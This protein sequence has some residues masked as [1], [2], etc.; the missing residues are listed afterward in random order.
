MV[1]IQISVG[2]T[3]G[4]DGT[5]TPVYATPGA[6]TASIG[7]TFTATASGTTLTVETV[8]SGSLQ[9]GDDV[10]GTDG[11]NSLPAGCYI[12]DQLT[13]LPGEAGTYELSAET[14][15]GTLNSCEVTSASTWLNVTGIAGGSF[16]ASASNQV[17]TV[18]AV[19][20]GSLWPGN[21]VAASDGTNS[22][23]NNCQIVKQLTGVQGGVGT[24]QISAGT[25]SGTLNSCIATIA[26]GQLQIG[27]TLSDGAQGL[28]PG[29]LITE[30]GTGVGAIGTYEINQQQTVASEVM[31]TI[32]TAL[33]QLQAVV[34]GDLRHVDALNLQGTHKVIYL[35][36]PLRGAVRASL[37]G[38]DLIILPNGTVWL[39]TQSLEPF[40]DTA[41]WVKGLITLQNDVQVA[42]PYQ[43]N[44]QPAGAP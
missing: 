39:W 20:T 28:V 2:S 1:G 27:Q 41:G 21:F 42:F 26:G 9:P 37:K 12:V 14:S 6:I 33:A 38:G 25:V 31:T 17:L 40:F 35:S 29:T 43:S 4:P 7:G 30:Y 16:T 8:L 24:Y 36:L 44:F 23:P 15:S 19:I 5:Q 22:L 10:S 13:G 11:V 32:M 34:G 18:S 3:N